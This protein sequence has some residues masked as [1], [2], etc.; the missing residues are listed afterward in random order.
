MKSATA[1]LKEGDRVK[2]TLRFRGREMAHQEVARGVMERVRRELDAY[3]RSNPTPAS[4][5]GR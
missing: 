3:A 2:I 4:K 5:A 1:F